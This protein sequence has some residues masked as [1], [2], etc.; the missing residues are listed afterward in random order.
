MNETRK[1]AELEIY[2]FPD[3]NAMYNS[4]T[5]VHLLEGFSVTSTPE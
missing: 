2:E 5:N 4:F 3:Q 1:Q